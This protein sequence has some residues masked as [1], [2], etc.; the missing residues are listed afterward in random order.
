MRLLAPHWLH[1]RK[2]DIFCT[3]KHNIISICGNERLTHLA[4]VTVQIK[5]V[6]T[7]VDQ[8]ASLVNIAFKLH[9]LSTQDF[10]KIFSFSTNRSTS[11]IVLPTVVIG[12]FSPQ[13]PKILIHSSATCKLDL[14][15]FFIAVPTTWIWARGFPLEEEI[16]DKKTRK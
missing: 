1:Y 2:I 9:P 3:T 4:H 15:L 11:N 13:I 14:S 16:R 10:L 5:N 6:W 8:C 12:A 7:N